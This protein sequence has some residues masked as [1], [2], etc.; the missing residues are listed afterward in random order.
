MDETETTLSQIATQISEAIKEKE[1]QKGEVEP[2][3]IPALD[4][5]IGMLKRQLQNIQDSERI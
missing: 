4:R 1:A 3:D 5:E 2:A